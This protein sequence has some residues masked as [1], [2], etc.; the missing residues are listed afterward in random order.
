MSDNDAKLIKYVSIVFGIIF[1]ALLSVANIVS[2]KKIIYG[3][4]TTI[5]DKFAL[6]DLDSDA[7]CDSSDYELAD[8]AIG[9]CV[10]SNKYISTIDVDN[11]GCI[12]ED[13]IK[14]IFPGTAS[15]EIKPEIEQLFFQIIE[16][17]DN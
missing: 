13:D 16:R 14:I 10:T 1:F 7:D 12:T 6:C 11:S 17:L 4:K 2:I 5:S 15:A 3:E 8:K 9:S